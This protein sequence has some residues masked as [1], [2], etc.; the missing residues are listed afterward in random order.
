MIALSAARAGAAAKA[1]N[2]WV[3]IAP[4]DSVTLIL[5]QAEIG[6]G[7]STTLPAILADELGADWSR[8]EIENADVAPAYQ[9]P[10]LHWMFTGN[11]ESISSFAAL[12]R[13][14]GAAAREMLIAAAVSRFGNVAPADCTT[15][16]GKVL[17]RPTGRSLS[18]GALAEAAAQL[19]VPENPTLRPAAELRLIGRSLARR[20]IPAK[21]DGSAVFGIDL[22]IPGMVHA[23]VR[24]SPVFGGV[25]DSFDPAA[26]AG[27]PGVIGAY[28]IPNGVA[29]VAEHFWQAKTAADLLPVTFKPGP[30]GTFDSA[31][32]DAQYRAALD[33]A[34]WGEIVNRG[35]AA[36]EIKAAPRPFVREYVSAFQA[37]AAME[38]MNCV[39]A[40]TSEGCDVWAPT[41]GPELTRLVAAA[42]TKLPAEKVRVHWTYSGGGFGRRLLADFVAQAVILALE[43]GRPV[44]VIWT[45]EED[46]S[47]DFYRPATLTR[48]AAALAPGGEPSAI[49][50]RLVSA[51]QLQPVSPAPLPPNVDPRCTEG[52]EDTHY[53]VAHFRL[54]YHRPELAAPTSVLRTT[55]FGPNVFAIESFIDEL[56]HEAGQDPYQFRRALLRHNA[57]ALRVLDLAAEKSGWGRAPEKGIGRGIA[58]YEAFD[59]FM[60]QVVELA[61]GEDKVVRLRRIVT[62]ADPGTV[63]DPGI[64]T[65]NLEG[66]VV[67]GLTCA[68]KSEI[69]F[70]GGAAEQTNFDGYDMV[71][72]W[73]TAP[74][75]ETYL[76]E[77]GGEKTGGMG[78]VGPTGIPAA[79][80][81]AIFAANG[82]RLRTLPLSRHGYSFAQS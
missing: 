24:Q 26:I 58:F 52:L 67:W 10:R 19:P 27:R 70:A 31:A 68:M 43:V 8:I 76:L 75:V 48:L 2:A 63:F 49:A 64:A 56:A 21:V 53:R 65:S 77:S 34:S 13:K 36:R 54:D 73:E 37:H 69:T 51:T 25:V 9:N 80:A 18:F 82:A 61:V 33:G 50:A 40:V 78:E 74:I 81:N 38:P 45:R 66:G 14:A 30:K 23:A 35:D 3:R 59:T 29:V 72:L 79:I 15:R 42:I 20:D 46:M 57:R 6:Q 41:Q 5:S 28:A 16:D 71:H 4:D 62:V 32:I 17:H 12:M 60:A 55:G 11:S 22:K 44:K 1:L 7:I 39:A 47:H